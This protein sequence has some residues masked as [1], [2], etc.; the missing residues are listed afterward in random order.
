MLPVLQIGPLALQL[1]G[2]LFL[3]S[4]WLGLSLAERFAPRRGVSAGVLYNLVFAA[5]LAGAAGARLSYILQYPEVFAANP[6]SALS[7][8][9]GL[10]DPWGGAAGA[11]LALLI[12][13]QHYQLGFWPTLDAL[14]PLFAV[15]A[16]GLALTNFSSGAG[17]GSPTNLPWGIELWGARRHPT[18]IY[19][20][21]AALIILVLLWPGRPGIQSWPSGKYFLTFV[22]LSALARLVLE[23]FRGDSRLVFGGLRLAQ[24]L[25]WLVMAAALW[26]LKKLAVTK[27]N[28][29]ASNL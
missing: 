7:L 18:Q 8:N 2:L 25:A 27:S 29:P 1:P 17:F 9:P 11:I 13:G 28:T 15:L 21:L 19:E 3:L 26:Q 14:T 20:A 10:L 23:A 12:L 5:L 16:I 22:L 4:L 6:R 24:A